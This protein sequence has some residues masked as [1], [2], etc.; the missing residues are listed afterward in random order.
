MELWRWGALR[1][2]LDLYGLTCLVVEEVD[3]ALS[4]SDDDS[5]DELSF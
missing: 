4:D 2:R 3:F 5:D 1:K